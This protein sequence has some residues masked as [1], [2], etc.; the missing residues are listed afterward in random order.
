MFNEALAFV[1]LRNISYGL[2][3]ARNLDVLD[4]SKVHKQFGL[5]TELRSCDVWYLENT[6]IKELYLDNNR[7]S[8]IERN[9]LLLF[10]TSLEVISADRNMFSYGPYVVQIGCLNNLKRIEIN[11][12]NTFADPDT[13]DDEVDINENT[14]H[15]YETCVVPESKG[16]RPN[17]HYL[18]SNHIN[19]WPDFIFSFPLNL[20]TL[21][22]RGWNLPL[23]PTYTGKP[24][25]P[26]KGRLESID[27]SQNVLSNLH[28]PWFKLPCLIHLNIS[29]NF[30]SVIDDNI[31]SAVPEL[32]TLDASNNFL[33]QALSEDIG[34]LV[35]K[36]LQ[37][38]KVLN[39]SANLITSLSGLSVLKSL[40]MLNL[41]FNSITGVSESLETLKNLTKLDFV[42]NKIS[43]L[44]LKLLRQLDKTA[45][46]T[47]RNVSV[48][49]SN[50]TL[51]IS[52]ENIEFLEWIV[53]H[54]NY[55][56]RVDTYIYR[57]SD[58]IEVMKLRELEKK[59]MSLKKTCKNYTAVIVISIIFIVGFIVCLLGGLVYRYRWRL[60]Y[61]YY[62]AKSRY[63]GYDIIPAEATEYKYDV[64]VSYAEED[65]LFTKDEICVELEENHGLEL[66]LHQR[67]FL[68]GNYIA[69]NI[70]QA[71]KN[72]RMIVIVL[73]D[74]FLNSK[75]CIY[76][77]NM[78]RMESIYSRNG[79]NFIVC[80]MLEEINN[81][82]LSPDLIETLD[83]ETFL[84]YPQ[85]EN[86]KPYF[87]EMLYRALSS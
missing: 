19:L 83:N 1:S 80:V 15:K 81:K 18:H 6:T 65:Y 55:F 51:E 66:C 60:R 45:Q 31:L 26:I 23:F 14:R 5:T 41:A 32:I 68:P 61:L 25:L 22:F 73:T 8:L 86:E 87:W 70:L 71:I 84:K 2:Q 46:R 77:Y 16:N 63:R 13:Y 43:T 39:L 50:N 47:S 57:S 44:P 72:S 40:E 17:C 48:D 3:S 7:L 37:H 53:Q 4:Y 78:T 21:S 69:E 64:F 9:A 38:L 42:Q 24:E 85:D 33:G 62:L 49:L 76:E 35:F 56:Q 75:W 58:G 27:A 74:K 10:P 82:F 36:P 79:E 34:G 59:V 28:T 52:C 54:P 30:A 11:H 29:N 67:N 20:T 12:Q